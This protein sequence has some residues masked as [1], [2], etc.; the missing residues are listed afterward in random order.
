ME[1]EKGF[2]GTRGLP[3]NPGLAR[4]ILGDIKEVGVAV[5]GLLRGEGVLIWRGH[6]RL[7]VRYPAAEA[8]A[9]GEGLCP[10]EET[11]MLLLL[12]LFGW[13]PEDAAR[14]ELWVELLPGGRAGE[15]EGGVW[16]RL[17][18]EGGRLGLVFS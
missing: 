10:W 14:P 8:E 13:R 12:L 2:P 7:G 9:A 11:T 3:P 1:G 17:P 15:R 6:V 16:A 5:S 4:C 18:R